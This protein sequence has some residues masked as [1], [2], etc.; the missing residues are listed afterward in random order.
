[1]CDSIWAFF[2]TIVLCWAQMLLCG[3]VTTQIGCGFNSAHILST[4][5]TS[6]STVQVSSVI[7]KTKNWFCIAK[8]QKNAISLLRY[9]SSGFGYPSRAIFTSLFNMSKIKF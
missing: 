4:I 8:K 9:I 2:V 1:M 5:V 3:L 7:L 6:N